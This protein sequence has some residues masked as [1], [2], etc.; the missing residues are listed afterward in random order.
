MYVEKA[1][2]RIVYL[3]PEHYYSFPEASVA[4]FPRVRVSARKLYSVLVFSCLLNLVGDVG[5]KVNL[6][7]TGDTALFHTRLMRPEK[8]TTYLCDRATLGRC[9]SLQCETH[10]V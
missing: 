4:A 3:D 8:G 5:Y 6:A 2:A 10:R 7:M 1:F 9:L